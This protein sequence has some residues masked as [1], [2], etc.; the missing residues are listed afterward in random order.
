MHLQVRADSTREGSNCSPNSPSSRLYLS[1]YLLAR[2]LVWAAANRPNTTAFEK[3]KEEEEAKAKVTAPLAVKKR[4]S[5]RFQ[6]CHSL[7]Q[8]AL[9]FSTTTNLKATFPTRE[10]LVDEI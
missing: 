10:Q 9:L 2:L 1:A 7:A 8:R 3:L 5:I 4:E 6:I